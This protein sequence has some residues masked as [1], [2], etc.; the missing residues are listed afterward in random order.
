M[1]PIRFASD[2]VWA[3]YDCRADGKG[4]HLIPVD[5]WIEHEFS[6]TCVCRPKL[7]ADEDGGMIV[8]HSAVDERE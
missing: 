1:P 4:V 8:T 6:T 5:D 3:A 7:D 2:G